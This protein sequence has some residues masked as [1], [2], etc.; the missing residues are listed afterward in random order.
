MLNSAIARLAGEFPRLNVLR[1]HARILVTPPPARPRAGRSACLCASMLALFLLLAT[2]ARAGESA[3]DPGVDRVIALVDG[4]QF[5]AAEARIAEGLASTS[6]SSDDK[7]ALSFQREHMRRT[8]LDFTL[9]ADDVK[10][11]LRK[12]IT[13]LR[14]DEFEKWDTDGL[15]ERRVI[16]GRVLYFSRSPSNLF[17]LSHE[18]LV[19]RKEQTPLVNSPLESPNPH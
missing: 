4:G 15:L 19:R 1:V 16:D 17:R 7:A 3:N 5:K 2:G 13:D 6:E 18:A 9:A 12:Q 11:R 8:L 10:A 14:D